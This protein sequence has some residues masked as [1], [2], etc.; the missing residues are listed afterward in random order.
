[1]TNPMELL[2]RDLREVAQ[3]LDAGF[4]RACEQAADLIEAQAAQLAERDAEIERGKRSFE[5]RWNSDL[6]AKKRWQEA[7]GRDME[8]PDYAD[9]SV[10]LLARLDAS[11]ALLQ[12]ARETAAAV[13][14]RLRVRVGRVQPRALGTVPWLPID[15]QHDLDLAT[16]LDAIQPG[17]SHAR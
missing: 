2:V 15:I 3:H 8:S 12:Q 1:M 11:E 7:T 10:W 13:A 14:E 6:R 5:V 17:D 16:T 4:D 9:L